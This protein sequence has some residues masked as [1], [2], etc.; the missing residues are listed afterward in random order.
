MIDPGGKVVPNLRD[1]HHAVEKGIG[2][3]AEVTYL[4]AAAGQEPVDDPEGAITSPKSQSFAAFG[5][6]GEDYHVIIVVAARVQ[7]FPDILGGI[8][9]VAVH[10][11]YIVTYPIG[12]DVGEAEGNGTLMAHVS[13]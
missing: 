3:S 5:A 13:A 12:M 4:D 8:F 9:A 10:D 1:A 6:F 7:Q 2:N 11:Y